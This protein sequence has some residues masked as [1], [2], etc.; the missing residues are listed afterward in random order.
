MDIQLLGIRK[1]YRGVQALRGVDL[2]LRGGE[3]HALVGQNGAG[4]STLIRIL[5]GATAPDA[6]AVLVDGSPARFHSPADAELSGIGVVHQESQ[7]FPD[8]SVADNV[9]AAH[10]SSRGIGPLRVRDRRRSR[11]RASELLYRLGIELDVTRPAGR[12]RPGERKLMEVARALSSDARALLLDEPT[13]AL[14]PREVGRLFALLARLRSRGV[15]ILFV[16]HKLDEVLAIANQVTVLRDGLVVAGREARTL[17]LDELVEMVA[18]AAVSAVAEEPGVPG[19]QL[20][21]AR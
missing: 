18:G 7:F 10:P 19:E 6:G 11:Q 1:S 5:T 17:S 12:L 4:K 20:V 3:V 2:H 16:S 8:L 9:L 21:R 13:A 15:A 14:E